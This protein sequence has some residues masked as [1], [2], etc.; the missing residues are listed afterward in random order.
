MGRSR[1]LW[2]ASVALAVG[3]CECQGPIPVEDPPVVSCDIDDAVVLPRD[4]CLDGEVLRRVRLVRGAGAPSEDAET[5]AVPADGELCVVVTADQA[6]AGWADVAGDEVASPRD[7]RGRP[8]RIVRRLSVPEGPAEL[9]ARLASGPGAT[10]DVT[11][12]FAPGE[13]SPEERAAAQDLVELDRLAC[14]QLNRNV[15]AILDPDVADAFV[16]GLEIAGAPVGRVAIHRTPHG[17]PSYLGPLPAEDHGAAT[18]PVAV[19]ESW[20]ERHAALMGIGART[21]F[22][23]ERV[24]PLGTGADVV[25]EKE[26]IAGLPVFGGYVKSV[27]QSG[28]VEGE[29]VFDDFRVSR[30]VR[31]GQRLSG[32][33]AATL[34][35]RSGQRRLVAFTRTGTRVEMI[36]RRSY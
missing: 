11:V 20:L 24:T 13:P 34:F 7:F 27:V 16:Q 12:R 22:V 8:A 28:Q 35:E 21:S 9:S 18:D 5:L 36:S 17:L 15:D 1:S 32:G 19:T 26:S 2:A 10:L 33:M 3:A 23:L 31:V 4:A 6:S 29:A 14:D 30:Q 25:L